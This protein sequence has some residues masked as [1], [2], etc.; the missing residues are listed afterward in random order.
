MALSIR[1]KRGRLTFEV[2]TEAELLIVLRELNGARPSPKRRG[3]S[4]GPNFLA[5]VLARQ[6]DPSLTLQ[7]LGSRI[8]I[9]RERARQILKR[10]KLQTRRLYTSPLVC[11]GGCGKR[12]N[13]VGGTCQGC[14]KKRTWGT[15]ECD[16]CGKQFERLVSLVQRN[17][18][19]P[20]SKGRV[21]CNKVCYGQWFGREHGTGK[22]TALS[23]LREWHGQHPE[24]ARQ[25]MRANLERARQVRL[26]NAQAKADLVW[27]KHLETGYGAVRLSRLLGMPA[28]TIEGLFRRKKLQLA[29]TS[30]TTS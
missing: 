18:R 14:R 24:E 22:N 23:K 12:T 30:A 5:V 4:P 29:V 27:A 8:G 20:G 11:A 28:K 17:L 25:M 9:S 16:D 3:P 6:N 13:R 2:D 1:I 19:I 7:A 26:E 10:A 21:F 15:F